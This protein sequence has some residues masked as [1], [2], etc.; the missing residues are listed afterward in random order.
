MSTPDISIDTSRLTAPE[1][2]HAAKDNARKE[3]KRS[4]RTLA[5]SGLAGGL[6]MGLTGLSVAAIRATL[7]E[8]AWAEFISYLAY[9]V[10]FIAV[11]IGRAQLFTENTL[12]PVLLILDERNKRLHYASHTARLWLVVFA[13]NVLGALCFAALV[14]RS[15]AL[16]GDLAVQLVRLGREAVSS[17]GSH[18][19]WSGIIGG[20]LIALVAWVVT[21]SHWTIGQLAMIWLLAF[22]VG[23]GHFSHC[24]ATSGEILSAVVVGAL[25]V[26]VYLRWLLFA[27]LGNIA[28]GVTMVSVLNYGQVRLD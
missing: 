17:T 28:G 12:Y 16:P 6:T 21:A 18:F 2:F 1:I 11:I 24:I 27:T 5:F 25:P 9:P 13:A 8:G 4:W 26:T 22:V 3:L 19:F 7:G 15:S 14:M 10:G 23:I 20:W